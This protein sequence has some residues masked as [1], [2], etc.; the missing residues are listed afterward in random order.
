ML[1]A[2]RL[3]WRSLEMNDRSEN[4]QVQVSVAG[5]YTSP[6]TDRALTTALSFRLT[7]MK[8]TNDKS[9]RIT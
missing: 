2:R 7:L 5:Q 9:S 6:I 3:E 1:R 4:H 8:I